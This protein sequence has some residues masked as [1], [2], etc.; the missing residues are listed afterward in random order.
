M[1]IIRRRQGEA[2]LI[3]IGQGRQIRIVVSEAGS[4]VALGVE[5]PREVAVWREEVARQVAETNQEAKRASSE[6]VLRLLDRGLPGGAA[7]Q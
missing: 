3:D 5:A 4:A 2:I 7:P 6:A 1:L